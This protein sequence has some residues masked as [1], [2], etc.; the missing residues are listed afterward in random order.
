MIISVEEI[1]DGLDEH[2]VALIQSRK[3]NLPVK[4]V[5]VKDGADY[6]LRGTF[7]IVTERASATGR[8]A[9]NPIDSLGVTVW[10]A[11]TNK[12]SGSGTG[13]MRSR[14]KPGRADKGDD[15]QLHRASRLRLLMVVSLVMCRYSKPESPISHAKHLKA[16]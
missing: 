10:A 8:A 15:D 2:I 12:G 1:D 7:M 14:G 11:G 4:L 6:F 16:L 9:V 13:V 5:A 3:E